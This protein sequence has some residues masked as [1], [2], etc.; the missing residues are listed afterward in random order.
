[1]ELVR[2]VVG[3]LSLSAC[4]SMLLTPTTEAFMVSSTSC[5]APSTLSYGSSHHRG[6]QIGLLGSKDEN[7]DT[8]DTIR[9][10]PP[11]IQKKEKDEP[12]TL[13]ELAERE[14]KQSRE[15]M[16]SLLF[17]QRLGQAITVFGYLFIASAFALEPFGYCY[18]IDQETHRLTIDTLE[19]KSFE[20]ESRKY[21]KSSTSTSTP[22]S[23]IAI[24]SIAGK[25]L[26]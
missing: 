7:H 26:L 2:I 21:M 1:M 17:P 18:T 6:F 9:D 3:V 25:E 5:G 4:W 24:S 13:Y 12:I 11:S 23:A 19:H 22:P 15:V 20:K 10:D 8:V 14:E 16:N